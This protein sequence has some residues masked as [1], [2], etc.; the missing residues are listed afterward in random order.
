VRRILS[1]VAYVDQSPFVSNKRAIVSKTLS[2]SETETEVVLIKAKH[3]IES[4]KLAP[5]FFIFCWSHLQDSLAVGI[6]HKQSI[7]LPR[8]SR[9]FCC[10]EAIIQSRSV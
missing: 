6:F 3:L 4:S 9:H 5:I 1:N 10:K 2:I 8:R 7:F